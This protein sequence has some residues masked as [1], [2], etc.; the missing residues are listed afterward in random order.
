MPNT[1]LWRLWPRDRELCVP[2]KVTPIPS[3]GAAVLRA[4]GWQQQKEVALI[5][6]ASFSLSGCPR[7][8]KGGVKVTPTKE[9]KEDPELKWVQKST[10]HQW[11]GGGACKSSGL[12]ESQGDA[13][14]DLNHVRI[15]PRA[16]T[17]PRVSTS[18]EVG[19]VHHLG[20]WTVR[21]DCYI[22]LHRSNYFKECYASATWLKNLAK[23]R[24]IISDWGET[25]QIIKSERHRQNMFQRT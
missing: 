12:E 3:Q 14:V 10:N 22:C 8:R 15:V 20:D 13:P 18:S 17:K 7:A 1:W 2:Q 16:G 21:K 6:C 9:E 24:K 5:L 25:Y 4:L 23:W 11:R 19:G